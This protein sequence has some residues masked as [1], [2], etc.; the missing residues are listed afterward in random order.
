MHL[1]RVRQGQKNGTNFKREISEERE[2]EI[3]E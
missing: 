2:A 3:R 1:G